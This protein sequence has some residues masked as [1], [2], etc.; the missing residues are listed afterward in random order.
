VPPRAA[1]KRP[2]TRTRP[3]KLERG[4]S[5]DLTTG[6]HTS[7]VFIDGGV[8]GPVGRVRLDETGTE[9]GDIS[10]RRYEIRADDPLSARASMVQESHFE[11]D[12]W[13]VR[14]ET[15]AEMTASA[16]AFHL[17]A[18]IVCH[19]GDTVFHRVSWQHDIPRNGM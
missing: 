4:L 12:D 10:E 14:I 2:F 19:D 18:T 17:H 15:T 1:K 16:N 6:V 8:F 3:G 13:S 5:H 7:R 11:R 9:M